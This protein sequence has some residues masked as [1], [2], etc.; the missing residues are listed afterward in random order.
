MSADKIFDYL[1]PAQQ[2]AVRAIE[3]PTLVI[4]GPGTGKT[5]VL[6]M[7]VANILLSTDTTA[8][9]ILCLTFTNKASINMKKRI[10][11]VVGSSGSKTVVK[12]FHS[13][14]SEIM[15]T[16]PDHFWNGADLTVAPESIQIEEI[17]NI[18]DNFDYDN[19][20][21]LK[22]AG[23]YTLIADIQK[24][25]G[26]CKDAGLTPEKLR[27]LIN[28]NVKYID[29][30]EPSLIEILEPK[31]SHKNTTILSKK[32]SALVD[33][34]T[35]Q[36]TKPLISLSTVIK[37]SFFIANG[38]DT[39]T[40]KTK[41][42][43]KWKS[44]WLQSIVG[45]KG[46]F[47]ERQRNSWWL[48]LADIYE[49]YSD[50]IHLR[51]Y[52]DYADMLVEVI[53]QLES[54]PEILSD[55][56]ERFSYV[57]IDEF[58]DT[59]QAQLR[60]AHLIADNPF[61][62][63]KP[64]IMAVGDDDQSI[65]KFNGAE[66]SN[67]L[68]FRRTYPDLNTIVL[69]Q[70]YRSNQYILDASK[71]V[72]DQADFRLVNVDKN[73]NKRLIADKDAT[74]GYIKAN[75]YSTREMQ[76]SIIS[77]EIKS[78][79]NTSKS[80][81]VL[82]RNHDSLIKISSI[83][84]QLKIPIQYEKQAN[85]LD[86]E[87][88]ETIYLIS[89]LI[90][91]IDNGDKN[92]IDGLIH[93]II[94]H[95]M[96]G[97]KPDDLWQIAKDNFRE[98]DWYSSIS[99]SSVKE[100]SK[101]NSWLKPMLTIS[102]QQPLSLSLEYIIGLRK[103][104]GKKSPLRNYYLSESADSQKYF[105]SLSAI[106]LLRSLA[107][108]F[109]AS[110]N[111]TIRDLCKLIEINR[112][113]NKIIADEAPYVSGKNPVHLLTVHKAKGLEFDEVYILDATE[114]IWKPS[115]GSRKPPANLPLQPA[116][117]DIDDYIR[118]MYVAITRARK[119]VCISSYRLDHSGKD[120]GVSNIIQ[121][122]FDIHEAQEE[123]KLDLIEALEES[124]SWPQLSTG[125]EREILKA[126]LDTYQ[127]SVTHL[128]NFL[129]I[130]KGGP[131]YFKE[132]NLLNLPETKPDHLSFGTAM[133]KALERAL[134]L[135]NEKHFNLNKIKQTYKV[136]LKSEQLSSLAYKNNLKKGEVLLDKLFNDFKFSFVA[137]SLAEQDIKDVQVNDAIIRGKLDR[138]DIGDNNLTI[139]DYKTGNALTSLSSSDKTKQ[140]KIWR[141]KTQLIFYAI[142]IKNSP[143]FNRYSD[144]KIEGQMTYLEADVASKMHLVYQPSDDEIDQLSK[145]IQMVYSK[146]INL[147]LPDVSNYEKDFIG[148][149]KFIDDLLQFKK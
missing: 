90:I 87:I 72:I 35:N 47:K 31:L 40:K 60:L 86:H 77:R 125:N 79:F 145:L 84:N 109:S 16:Y 8:S 32:I 56:Q 17:K 68:D 3:G 80:I 127:L 59:N 112:D 111:P 28:A 97:I 117:D 104:G 10:I 131:T 126:R 105:E 78:K 120:V 2:E 23:Q 51:G 107:H 141:S 46:M 27:T 140:E 118:L 57:L 81:A 71:K 146:I 88:V 98:P 48:N 54:N 75:T 74:S 58:Q 6:A 66:I 133:H 136:T 13:L 132:K 94:R 103:I 102:M 129:D 42:L 130:A 89:K 137:N 7:R 36:I 64:S 73:L 134:I 65:F 100:I 15:N 139:I 83:L 70:N 119:N 52:Y 9:N 37:E 12:T 33:Q 11:D 128:M 21:A 106:Q 41:Y 50:S 144:F 38:Q 55:L 67:M 45:E 113:N 147:D 96:W 43:G 148:T 24:A 82:A 26:L 143:R 95:P 101:F 49:K 149:Q 30:V 63:G 122:A 91:S 29:L 108:E 99:N 116:G 61:S 123:G 34:D 69:T 53:S 20:L 19:P 1:N 18:L 5:E 138:L 93:K 135:S 110:E 121:S 114:N 76:Y 14:A 39:G 4:A 115:K 62:N 22:F 25:I 142:L 124:I 85:V 92:E 44:R